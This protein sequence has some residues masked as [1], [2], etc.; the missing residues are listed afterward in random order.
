MADFSSPL[1]CGQLVLGV[2]EA[3][4]PDDESGWSLLGKTLEVLLRDSSRNAIGSPFPV[5]PLHVD[6]HEKNLVG[7]LMIETGLLRNRVTREPKKKKFWFL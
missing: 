4:V 5:P 6:I 2:L 1:S 7:V 3:S